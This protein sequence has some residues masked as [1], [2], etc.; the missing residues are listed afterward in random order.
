MSFG[1]VMATGDIENPG[2][3]DWAVRKGD[4]GQFTV[5]VETTSEA[6]PVVVATGSVTGD[7]LAS[8]NVVTVQVQSTTMFVVMSRDVAGWAENQLQDAAF[9]FVAC[10]P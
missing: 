2:S 5:R 8:D 9:S 4:A 3:G 6:M 7:D 10:W 1:S